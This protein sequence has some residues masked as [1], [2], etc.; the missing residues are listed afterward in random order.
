M[1]FASADSVHRNV[2][3]GAVTRWEE[4]ARR[5]WGLRNSYFIG[6]AW[7]LVKDFA[8]SIWFKLMANTE[9]NNG[10]LYHV[11][12]CLQVSQF[13]AFSFPTWEVNYKPHAKTFNFSWWLMK[14]EENSFI[15]F[16]LMLAV[17]GNMRDELAL[18]G[19]ELPRSLLLAICHK[20]TSLKITTRQTM[21]GKRTDHWCE[22]LKL[23][24]NKRKTFQNDKKVLITLKQ[25]QFYSKFANK[26]RSSTRRFHTCCCG[27]LPP[28]HS[29]SL[30]KN[31]LQC[32]HDLTAMAKLPTHP[33]SSWWSNSRCCSSSGLPRT[34]LLSKIENGYEKVVKR[35]FKEILTTAWS[36]FVFEQILS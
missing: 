9:W 4:T 16:S 22:W 8:R 34:R 12:M 17:D 5:W 13:N 35:V 7:C 1:K 25:H 29:R 32:N 30:P 23:I 18:F 20:C 26:G 3:T 31:G 21:W 24:N 6:A 11:L 14:A 27:F 10:R 36:S 15:H 2:L 33:T 19:L 28:M